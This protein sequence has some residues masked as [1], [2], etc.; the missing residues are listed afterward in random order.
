MHDNTMNVNFESSK[1]KI[2]VG[3]WAEWLALGVVLIQRLRHKK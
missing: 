1:G 3:D 2:D